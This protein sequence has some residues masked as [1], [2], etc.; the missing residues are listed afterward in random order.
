MSHGARQSALPTGNEAI[1]HSLSNVSNLGRSTGL[2]GTKDKDERTRQRPVGGAGADNWPFKVF[3]RMKH[4]PNSPPVY[5]QHCKTAVLAQQASDLF[6][7]LCVCVL[8]EGGGGD[9]SGIYLC[10]IYQT[11]PGRT[12]PERVKATPRS[13]SNRG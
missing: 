8:G 13:R 1:Q 7:C 2:R 9:S 5:C 12:R 11:P 10:S 4:I 3:C 6:V